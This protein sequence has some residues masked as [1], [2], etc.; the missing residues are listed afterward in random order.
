MQME[1]LLI[2]NMQSLKD[3]KRLIS[4]NDCTIEEISEIFQ[5]AKK[6]DFTYNEKGNVI[7]VFF[8]NST[9]TLLSFEV[10]ASNLGLKSIRFDV[11]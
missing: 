7:T 4:I 1:S 6:A 8:E 3:C 10:A 5:I 2:S 11:S 9:R